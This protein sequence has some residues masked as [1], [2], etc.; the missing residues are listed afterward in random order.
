M[1]LP[2]PIRREG[3][4]QQVFE[5]EEF[6]VDE[7]NIDQFLELERRSQNSKI[8]L[9]IDSISDEYED[10]DADADEDNY[11]GNDIPNSNNN[12]NNNNNNNNNNSNNNQNKQQQQRK[13][14]FKKGISSEDARRKR[15]ESANDIRKVKRD[16]GLLKR[17]N[18]GSV[19]A[20]PTASDCSIN[21]DPNNTLANAA[22][23][24]SSSSASA[25]VLLPAHLEALQSQDYA[26]QLEA[27]I[28]VRKMLS[29]EK[30][31]PIDTVLRSGIVPRIIEFLN[32]FEAP[33][34]Q[35][36]A[37]WVSWNN[38]YR[39]SSSYK[40]SGMLYN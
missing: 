32:R 13:K 26:H 15:E 36:E 6:E 9:D 23:D 31:P 35:F 22:N 14:D 25:L 16:E 11:N 21:V 30:N 40:K 4:F 27:C 18:F 12:I 5:N 10:A 29:I 17:R 37:A 39:Q 8:E 24:C 2:F 20:N 38:Y 7:A 28:H 34:L 33:K 3:R 19:T 1:I